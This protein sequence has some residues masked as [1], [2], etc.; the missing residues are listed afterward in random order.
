[1][2]IFESKSKHTLKRL[3]PTRWFFRY[4]S[5]HSLRFH[6]REVLQALSKILLTST[7]AAEK[8]EAHNLKSILEQLETVLIIVTESKI[9]TFYSSFQNTAK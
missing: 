9:L 8:S 2:S 4:Q 6:Y 7:K 3:C 5:L 1:M